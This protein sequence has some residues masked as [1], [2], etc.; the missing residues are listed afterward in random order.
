M[1]AK[2]SLSAFVASIAVDLAADFVK[3][4]ATKPPART[5]KRVAPAPEKRLVQAYLL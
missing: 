3:A 1:A 2:A 4:S 5:T